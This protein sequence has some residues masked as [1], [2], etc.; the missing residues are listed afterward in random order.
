MFAN[1]QNVIDT[2]RK[3]TTT[4]GD[5][6]NLSNVLSTATR[7]FSNSLDNVLTVRASVGSRMQE[8]DALVNIDFA[9][10]EVKPKL[11]SLNIIRVGTSGSLQADIPVDHFVAS[12]HGLGG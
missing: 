2:L 10:R 5:Q 3:P 7:Q 1:L 6:A 4:P 12:T 11:T 9:T 8:L